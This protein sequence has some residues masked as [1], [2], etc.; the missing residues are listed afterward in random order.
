MFEID[1]LINQNIS[2]RPFQGRKSKN[3]GKYG[4]RGFTWCYSR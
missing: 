1:P 4:T 2:V 3:T